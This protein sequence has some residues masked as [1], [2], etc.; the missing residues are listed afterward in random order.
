MPTENPV[1]SYRF[2]AFSTV[3]DFQLAHSES[4]YGAHEKAS[5]ISRTPG[6]RYVEILDCE[7]RGRDIWERREQ[8]A[9]VRHRYPTVFRGEGMLPQLPSIPLGTVSG[10]ISIIERDIDFYGSEVDR[11]QADL[12][13]CNIWQEGQV[14][15][16][17][18][19]ARDVLKSLLLFQLALKGE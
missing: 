15:K 19:A 11:L 1:A 16:Q 14:R 18:A 7:H 10:G 12:R 5:L 17:I 2:I 4:P 6:D 3:S 9:S 8:L 13:R